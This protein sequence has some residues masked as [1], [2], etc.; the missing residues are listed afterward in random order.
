MKSSES[1]MA[2][3]NSA[4]DI[5]LFGASKGS[6]PNGV[7]PSEKSMDD[8]VFYG[9]NCD[10]FVA[11]NDDSIPE[12][13]DNCVYKFQNVTASFFV[14]NKNFFKYSITALFLVGFSVYFGFAVDY[15]V[16]K[17]M[18]LIVITAIV[19]ALIIYVFIR[20]HFGD[21]ITHYLWEPIETFLIHQWHWFRW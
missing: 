12:D 10:E 19:V 6:K 16:Q 5:Q 3:V 7:L 21:T 8:D 15:S 13:P 11:A 1:T 14:N 20:D 2:P 9:K 18:A 4:K 17:S